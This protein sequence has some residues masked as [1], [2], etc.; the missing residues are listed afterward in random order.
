MLALLALA[1]VHAATAL[2]A[3]PRPRKV[4]CDKR[5]AGNKSV[6]DFSISELAGGR[7]LSLA[8]YR[9][10]VLLLVNVATY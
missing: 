4:D 6:Y 7:E 3:E 8:Q 10:H 5:E 1:M 2:V 9:G